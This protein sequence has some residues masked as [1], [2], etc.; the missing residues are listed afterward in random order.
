VGDLLPV[1]PGVEPVSDDRRFQLL[2]DAVKD[3]AIYMLDPH[4]IVSSWNS[5]AQRFKGYKADEIIGQ[6]FSRFYTDEDRQ[7]G[8]PQQ[9][10][11]TAMAEG[12][13]ETEGWRVRKDGSRFWASVVIN[14]IR[15]E[16][17]N[18]FGFAKITRDITERKTAEAALRRSEEQFRLLVQGVT[19]YA[20]FMLDP[21]GYVTN[22]NSGA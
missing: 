4:G 14:P 10:L 7:A 6:H 8:V 1:I 21:A 2:V 13:Y 9:A 11:A 22:W 12:K 16:S 20:I 3:Y 18:L 17:G 15:D 19:D 5:G